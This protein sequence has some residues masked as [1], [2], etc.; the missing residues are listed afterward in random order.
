MFQSIMRYSISFV[1][2]LFTFI[3]D[4]YLVALCHNENCRE[5]FIINAVVSR[6]LLNEKRK[7]NLMWWSKERKKEGRKEE[8]KEGRICLVQWSTND[9]LNSKT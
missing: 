9:C 7:F 1:T 4:L 8:W 5:T 3:I 2:F 6:E